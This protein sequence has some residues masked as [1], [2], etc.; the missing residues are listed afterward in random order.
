MRTTLS[1]PDDQNNPPTSY[2]RLTG[3]WLLYYA[4]AKRFMWKIPTQDRPDVRHSIMMELADAQNR[5]G[6]LPLPEAAMYRIASFEVADYWRKKKRSPN[7]LSLDGDED[8]DND[9]GLSSVLPDDSALDLDA[10]IDA[11]T[12]LLSCPKR[13]IQIAFKRVNGV[14]LDGAERKYLCHF[15]KREQVSFCG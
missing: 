11:R 12:F 8:A 15:R 13:L 4:V 7:L 10:W 3:D 2:D 9:T 14:T 6:G 1:Y 5:K